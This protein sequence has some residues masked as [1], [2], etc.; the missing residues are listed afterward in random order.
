DFDSVTGLGVRGRVDGR[1]LALGSSGYMRELGIA[2]EALDDAAGRLRDEGASVVFL[3]VDGKLAGAIAVAD[4]IK[5]ST[6][7]AIRALHA[8]G[9]RIVMATGDARATAQAVGARLGIDEIHGEV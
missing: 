1:A 9:L 5:V 2:T 4:P 6:P 8:Q 7:D 3:A